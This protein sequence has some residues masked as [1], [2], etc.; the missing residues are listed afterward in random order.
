MPNVFEEITAISTAVIGVSLVVLIVMLLVAS[1]RARHAGKRLEQLVQR[2]FDDF[3][4]VVQRVQTTLDDLKPV[5][6]RGKEISR[7]VSAMTNSIRGDVAAVSE[8]VS[9]ANDKVRAAL[10]ATEERLAEFNALLDV[11]QNEAEDL[12][13]STAAAVRGVGLGAASLGRRRGTDLA[14]KDEDGVA[15][16]DAADEEKRDADQDDDDE[17]AAESP[18]PR[19]RSRA[20][21]PRAS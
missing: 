11:V 18:A 20:R 12:F 2:A 21:R 14:S 9:S 6:E 10:E 17:S 7:D 8:T 3:K 1:F 5:I 15:D 13:V 16:R 4:P 19:V